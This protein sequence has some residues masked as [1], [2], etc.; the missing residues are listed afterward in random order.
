MYAHIQTYELNRTYPVENCNN[1]FAA[2]VPKIVFNYF[3]ILPT[4][5]RISLRNFS[6]AKVRHSVA[7]LFKQLV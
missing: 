5:K 6:L 7:S 2:K 1:L 4:A 3:D